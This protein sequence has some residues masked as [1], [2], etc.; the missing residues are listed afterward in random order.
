MHLAAACGCPSVAMFGRT[1]EDHWSPWRAPYRAVNAVDLTHIADPDERYHLVKR[2]TMK[3]TALH[4]VLSA[5]EEMLAR[6]R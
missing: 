2:R 3:D 4:D 5:C 1:F 6:P